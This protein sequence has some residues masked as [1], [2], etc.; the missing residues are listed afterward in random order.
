MILWDIARCPSLKWLLHS[1]L[2]LSTDGKYW[3][4]FLLGIWEVAQF[5]VDTSAE[6]SPVASTV[7]PLQHVR[8]QTSLDSS[9]EGTDLFGG[10]WPIYSCQ[11]PSS[12]LPW[13]MLRG[14]PVPRTNLHHQNQPVL[15]IYPTWCMAWQARTEI[16]QRW[17][18]QLDR[19]GSKW[20]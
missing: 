13:L 4:L 7:G 8:G 10:R 3:W 17:A 15:G 5:H 9:G 14:S 1:W 18:A 19:V 6:Q 11:P 16:P 20:S 12:L 2:I